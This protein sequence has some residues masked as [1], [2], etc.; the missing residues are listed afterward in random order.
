[1]TLDE[2]LRQ[3][4][5]KILVPN[6]WGTGFFV[7]EGAILTCAHVVAAVEAGGT[8]TFVWQGQ[9]HDATV[10]HK[11]LP[12]QA[13]V[14]LLRFTPFSDA[15][16][17]VYL[18][19]E[20]QPF[21]RAFTYG[22]P[23]D[24]QAGG[25]PATGQ[26]DGRGKDVDGA[27]V[28]GFSQMQ[29]KPGRSGS[30]LLNLD[31][32]YVCGII[33]FT[34]EQAGN[35]GGGAVPVAEILTVLPE[36]AQL[37]AAFH[38]TNTT[39]KERLPPALGMRG[40]T[41]T[42]ASIILDQQPPNVDQFQGREAELKQIQAELQEPSVRLIEIT[43]SGGYG[44]T[45]LVAKALA[46]VKERSDLPTLWVSFNQPY[47][48]ATLGRWLL[49][50]LGQTVDEK[51][52]DDALAL[53][54]V[55]HLSERRGLLVLDNLETLLQADGQWREPVYG[56]FFR[57][58]LSHGQH[59]TILL[60]SREQVPL[61]HEEQHQRFRW[62][63]LGGLSLLA[64]VALLKAK[65]IRG[66][67]PDLE[68]FV[69]LVD[70]HPLSL[71]LTAGW[72]LNPRKTVAPD[73]T[74]ALKQDDLYRFEQI[75]GDHR[76]DPDASV[77][78]ILDASVERLTPTLQT[79]WQSLSVYRI[80]F[81]LVAAQS[82][83]PTTTLE[84]L[85]E[86]ARRSLLQEQQVEGAVSTLAEKWRFQ[87]SPLVQRFAQQQLGDLTEAHTQAVAYY[88]SVARPHPWQQLAEVTA[89][90]EAF[91]HLYQ[92]GRYAQAR[93]EI[94]PCDT[95]LDLQGYN[96]IR[97][98]L[99]GRLVRAWQQGAWPIEQA[100][101][102]AALLASLVCW[103]NAYS[104]LAQYAPAIAAHQL[105]LNLARQTDSRSYEGAALGNLGLAYLYQ[106]NYGQAI[107]YSQQWL[108]IAQEIGDRASEAIAW[109]NLGTTQAKLKQSS[110]AIQS[111]ENARSLYQ[112]MGL[113]GDVQD[114]DQRIQ[115]LST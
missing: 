71:S 33:K 99:Y 41:L 62:C 9:E 61:P 8:V 13:D 22:F 74:Y 78:R 34:H 76:G 24:F 106:G 110:Q 50:Q 54:M 86:L 92:L 28:L 7:G 53:E 65:G 49:Q 72:L 18:G 47:A 109:F 95:F 66:A 100:E 48:F 96:S 82:M 80:S 73:V 81:D 44:K 114:C 12:T 21:Q 14:A 111:Y 11:G 64:G 113:E 108:T 83:L 56:A 6:D 103:G 101:D 68:R 32:G 97:L 17:C 79:L 58:W 45:F 98:E 70:G 2:L 89:Y 35:F 26:F 37:Q 69:A 60:T 40:Q 105:L 67:E 43:A 75:V 39:W 29:V 87:F 91:H 5:V 102:V 57:R 93:R 30:P 4:I 1:M 51:L 19:A 42:A 3:C 31:T 52:P 36:V 84:D 55:K 25:F 23:Q 10:V 90:L 38:Q 115:Q 46:Q 77:G 94:A 107:D 88:R 112:Q 15:L 59:C 104:A 16:P 85:W 63:A 20:A 27:E